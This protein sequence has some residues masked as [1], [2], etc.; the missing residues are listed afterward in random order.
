MTDA[1]AEDLPPGWTQHFDDNHQTAYWFNTQ[2]GESSWTRPSPAAAAPVPTTAAVDF[3]PCDTFAG[4]KPGHVFTT[5]SQGTGYYRDGSQL[6]GGATG[7]RVPT[8]Q[9]TSD[10]PSRPAGRGR[11]ATMPAWMAQANRANPLAAA[12]G[13]AEPDVAAVAYPSGTSGQAQMLDSLLDRIDDKASADLADSGAVTNSTGSFAGPCNWVKHDDPRSGKPYYYNILTNETCSEE[14]ADYVEPSSMP[15]WQPT[16][17]QT[18][19]H[20]ASYTDYSASASF[21]VNSGRFGFAGNGSYWERMG[22]PDDREGR[23]MHNFF[24]LS[25]LEQNRKEAEQKKQKLKNVDWRKYKEESKKRKRLV[26]ERW[27]HDD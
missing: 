20:G 14:P 17:T 15:A 16:E 19:H 8:V 3:E 9:P 6:S 11:G 21:N 13:A 22:R 2:T 12:S 27:L 1:D 4:A 25:T 10:I 5:G 24:D 7:E 18:A 26:R 23:Q